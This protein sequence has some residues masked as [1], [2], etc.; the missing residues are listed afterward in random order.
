MSLHLKLFGGLSLVDAETGAVRVTR[1]HRLATLAILASTD[2]PVPRERLLALL[3]PDSSDE[4]GRHSLGQVLY[5]LRQDL[6]LTDAVGGASDLTLQRT[7]IGCDLWIFRAA[8]AEGDR[9][10]ALEVYTGPF[11]DGIHLPGADPFDRWIDEERTSL[12]RQAR[13]AMEALATEADVRRDH[14]DALRW[15]RQLAAADPISSR[16]ALSFMRALVASGDR[17][18]ALQ[19]ARVHAAV[20]R[21][22]LDVDA[23]P[24]VLALAEDLKNAPPVV[25]PPTV[26]RT[27]DAP[28]HFSASPD[29]GPIHRRE[30]PL[31]LSPAIQA[32][33]RRTPRTWMVAAAVLVTASLAIASRFL[34]RRDAPQRDATG[35]PV[36][37]VLPF[38]V[39][40]DTARAFLGEALSALLSTRLDAPGVLRTL[41]SNTVLNAVGGSPGNRGDVADA[42]VV[43]L[44]AGVLVRG[45]VVAL[46]D[47]LEID[48]ELH[49]GDGSD[50]RVLRAS[51]SGSADSLFAL[52]DRLGAELLVKREGR[53]LGSSLMGGT[54][55]VPALKAFLSGE[56]SLRAW[57]LNDATAAYREAL[58]IDS[59]YAMA[60]YRLGF[61]Q[62]WTKEGDGGAVARRMTER[63]ASQLP[64][65]HAMLVA[66]LLARQHRDYAAAERGFMLLVQRY[67]DDADPWA[68]LGE[69]RMHVGPLLGRPTSDAEAP[70]AHAL[71]LDSARHPEVR[72]HLTQLALERGDT[73]RAR[74]LVAPLLPGND[75]T[76]RTVRLLQL[77]TSLNATAAS[78]LPRLVSML[79]DL[80]ARDAG[81]LLRFCIFSVGSTPIARALVDSLAASADRR[82]YRVVGLAV[83]Q[84]MAVARRRWNEVVSAGAALAALDSVAAAEGWSE[85]ASSLDA[86][87]PAAE[88]RRAGD[89]LERAASHD[90][91]SLGWSRRLSGVKLAAR[92][93]DDAAYARRLSELTRR[94]RPPEEFSKEVHVMRALRADAVHDTLGVVR[95]LDA[96][97]PAIDSPLGRVL[98]A[99]SLERLGQREAASNWYLSSPWGPDAVVLTRDALQ[100]AGAIAAARGNS[101]GAEQLN[102]RAAHFG[103]DSR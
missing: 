7:S 53:V 34:P 19:H 20:V 37:A 6:D 13:D 84:E 44:G 98:R 101:A 17:A 59:S 96:I 3:W 102:R 4:S 35:I 67:P 27:A 52:A 82:E 8:L 38:D 92:A 57:Q 43:A 64:P 47:H 41:E 73:M 78:E 23:D 58:R 100:H 83:A 28:V 40:G 10:R 55:S 51:V 90:T 33:S 24:A 80:P 87:I 15:W 36:A 91:S 72:Y 9:A 79:H 62:G 31:G 26:E 39:R 50:T 81:Q 21:A 25:A 65:R 66:A 86:Q 1:R 75:R 29:V 56:R 71:V 32:P 94:V 45:T 54:V 74:V 69:F 99:R 48:A 95:E 42:R 12:A 22:E 49:A 93:G 14:A 68:E 30:T 5:G 76:D 89:V 18:A 88:Y 2:R 70:L 60:W 46:G 61:V 77:M 63:F 16:V 97:G 103:G 85:V 11:L